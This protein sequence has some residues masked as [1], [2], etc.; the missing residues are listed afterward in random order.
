[1][2]NRQIKIVQT[3]IQRAGSV[4]A[5][6][7]RLGVHRNTIGRWLK[8]TQEMKSGIYMELVKWLEKN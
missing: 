1:V 7:I 4:N 2:I 3:A 8:G 6:A 5:L